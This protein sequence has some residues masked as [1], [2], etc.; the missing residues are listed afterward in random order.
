MGG[1]ERLFAAGALALIAAGCASGGRD[2]K[3]EPLPPRAVSAVQP[4]PP[5]P[6]EPLVANPIPPPTVVILGE[7]AAAGSRP[8]TLAEAS[9]RA[10]AER[11]QAA[12]P[13]VVITDKNLASFVAGV[14]L[15][16]AEPASDATPAA[17]D[18]AAAGLD[19]AEWRRRGLEIRQRWKDAVEAVD[20]LEEEAADLRTRF[21]AA[22]DPYV[23]DARI[24]PQWDRVLGELAEARRRAE[25]GP[26]EVEKFLEEGRRAGALPGWLRTG[27]ELEPVPVVPTVDGAAPIEPETAPEPSGP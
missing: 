4:E 11:E 5:P 3:P 16:V 6:S 27:S 22:D 26:R 24:K 1:A 18:A 21:Y 19:E 9:R 12:P 15:T 25:E 14:H 23:R 7:R 10:K 2:A 8:E 13:V 20:R 17:P